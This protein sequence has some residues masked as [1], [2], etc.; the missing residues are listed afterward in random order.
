M[1]IA[2][3]ESRALG[4]FSCSVLS[5]MKLMTWK[6]TEL[7]CELKAKWYFYTKDVYILHV[8]AKENDR[9]VSFNAL[10]SRSQ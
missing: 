3:G 9:F 1:L 6:E 7:L 5:R 10:L 8:V 2:F 4:E